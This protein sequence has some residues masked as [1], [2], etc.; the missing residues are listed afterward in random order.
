MSGDDNTVPLT[1]DEKR[2]INILARVKV[3]MTEAEILVQFEAEEGA[4]QK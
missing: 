3:P 4:Q 2:I 1:D